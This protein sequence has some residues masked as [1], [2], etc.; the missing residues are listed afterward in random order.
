MIFERTIVYKTN[1]IEGFLMYMK[2]VGCVEYGYFP[3][4]Q[5]IYTL[6]KNA[7]VLITLYP[8]LK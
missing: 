1:K 8:G 5:I 7:G 2:L 3:P 6:D 4:T